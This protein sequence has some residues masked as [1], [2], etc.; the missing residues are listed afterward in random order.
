MKESYF[1]KPAGAVYSKLHTNC[2]DKSRD[3]CNVEY[4]PPPER[5]NLLKFIQQFHE[6][7]IFMLK[8]QSLPALQ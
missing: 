1:T 4:C 8:S 7:K 3:T 6:D 2:N 5:H